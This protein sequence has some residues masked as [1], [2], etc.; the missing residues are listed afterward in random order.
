[1]P[2]KLGFREILYFRSTIRN[3]ESSAPSIPVSTQP[4]L[5]NSMQTSLTNEFRP[6]FDFNSLLENKQNGV[7]IANEV[8]E[9][10]N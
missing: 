6:K 5:I 4:T 7:A 9:V 8:N 2:E 10:V 3:S 1:M